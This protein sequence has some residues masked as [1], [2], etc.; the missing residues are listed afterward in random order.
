MPKRIVKLLDLTGGPVAIGEYERW[1][2]PRAVWPEVTA[3]I[4]ASGV[5]DMEIWRFSDRL[6][7]IAEV[8]D[9]YPRDIPQ[10]EINAEWEK[11]MGRYQ[12]ALPDAPAGEKWAE[13]VRIYSLAEQ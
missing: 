1:H 2:G 12:R 5:I 10:S 7:M 8:D 11:L 4:R 9:D 3:H 13:A 6:V